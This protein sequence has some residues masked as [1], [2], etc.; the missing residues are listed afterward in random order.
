MSVCVCVQVLFCNHISDVHT[1]LMHFQAKNILRDHLDPLPPVVLARTD[2]KMLPLKISQAANLS[3]L[4]LPPHPP[5][6]P[7]PSPLSFFSLSL[8][9]THAHAK[10]QQQTNN[11][12]V[13]DTCGVHYHTHTQR[14]RERERERER[15]TTSDDK[16]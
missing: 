8:T 16:S 11:S 2:S 10:L 4:S 9:H 12:N 14:E 6:L 7:A 5:F 3:S 1:L 13:N 15:T